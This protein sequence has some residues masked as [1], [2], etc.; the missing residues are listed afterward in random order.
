MYIYIYTHKNKILLLICLFKTSYLIW[1]RERERKKYIYMKKKYVHSSVKTNKTTTILQSFK[2]EIIIIF[3][4]YL[5]GLIKII[6][7]KYNFVCMRTRTHLNIYI[8]KMTV[9]FKI[10][11][12]KYF[13]KVQT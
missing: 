10:T 8:F 4:I 11:Y 12:L 5:H 7:I 3:S 13:C 9:L 1:K 2:I 6:I